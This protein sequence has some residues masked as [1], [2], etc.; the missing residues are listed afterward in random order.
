M[1]PRASVWGP[2]VQLY[3]GGWAGNQQDIIFQELIEIMRAHQRASKWTD[4]KVQGL[5]TPQV[6]F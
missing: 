3:G 4:I 1:G 2:I 5:S 6:S